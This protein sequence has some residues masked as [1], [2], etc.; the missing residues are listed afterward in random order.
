MGC[1]ASSV[2]LALSADWVGAIGQ[3]VGALATATAVWVALVGINAERTL[4]SEARHDAEIAQ[5]S[6]VQASIDWAD[7]EEE[8]TRA[9]LREDSIRVENHGHWPVFDPQIKTIS[10]EEFPHMRLSRTNSAHETLWKDEPLDDIIPAGGTVHLP[11]ELHDSKRNLL[12][13]SDAEV[14][15][16]FKDKRG[17]TWIRTGLQLPVKMSRP[18]ENQRKWSNRLLRRRSQ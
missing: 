5:A 8:L 12:F 6:D 16:S 17:T 2:V 13:P 9:G 11:F 14:T 10:S 15:I 4:A 3:V 7:P 18:A 1:D